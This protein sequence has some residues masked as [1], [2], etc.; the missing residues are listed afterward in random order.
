MFLDITSN[1]KTTE[2]FGMLGFTKGILGNKRKRSADS[3][4]QKELWK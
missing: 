4:I 3:L 1:S 2:V